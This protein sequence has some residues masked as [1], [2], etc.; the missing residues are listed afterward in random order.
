VALGRHFSAAF[1]DRVR[2][3]RVARIENPWVMRV[4]ARLGARA[5]AGLTGVRG[6]CFGDTVALTR[7][8]EPV[9][10]CSV[11]FHELVHSAQYRALGTRRFLS[12]YARSWLDAGRVYLNIAFEEEAYALQERFDAGEVF[13][14]ER[15]VRERLSR[16]GRPASRGRG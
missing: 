4:A 5:S 15:E 2:V 8:C 14:T 3:A 7:G 10:G 11:L 12:A 16:S 13:D 1:L 6:M 9:G